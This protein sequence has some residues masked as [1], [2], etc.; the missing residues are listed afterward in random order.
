MEAIEQHIRALQEEI[1][2][3][4]AARAPLVITGSG[5]KAQHGAPVQGKVLDVRSVRGIV[6]YEPRELVLVVRAGTPLSEIESVVEEA[7]QML[8]FEPPH[9][10]AGATIGGTVATG[11]SGP[12]RAYAG[13]VRDFM[14]GA[15]IIDGLGQDLRFGGKVIKNVAGYDA[16]RLMAGACGTLGVLL[17]IAFKVLPRPASEVTL[18][19]EMDGPAAIERMNLWA[20]NPLPLSATSWHQGVLH[21][22]LSGTVA[23]VETAVARLGGE[24]VE[25]G[26]GFW[27]ALREQEAAFFNEAQSLA[28][29][30]LP[31]TTLANIR[32][33]EWIEQ[34]GAQRWLRNVED[35]AALRTEVQALG[36]HVTFLRGAPTDLPRFHP[37]P[38]PLVALHRR[39][40]QTF[41][42][43]G[44]LN[45]GRLDNF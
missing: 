15:R 1:K 23:G 32:S 39:L 8:P 20:G 16:T 38:P 24:K 4:H 9:Y 17:E 3:A 26:A 43:A 7:G 45:P 29:V 31:A 12:R 5:S 2:T 25:D 42:P 14:L 21:V 36:G 18:R 19:F 33:D 34:G 11:L 44:I 22:R 10:A 28:R 37:L 41:D 30:S 27:R 13:A 35:P 40:K 6:D